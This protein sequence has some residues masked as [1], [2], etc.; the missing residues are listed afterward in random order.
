MSLRRAQRSPGLTRGSNLPRGIA[1]SLPLLAMTGEQNLLCPM[2]AP[3]IWRTSVKARNAVIGRI[4]LT[5]LAALALA[6]PAMANPME[7]GS[8]FETAR[9]TYGTMQSREDGMMQA[10]GGPSYPPPEPSSS[11]EKQE[12]RCGIP[13][14]TKGIPVSLHQGGPAYA[15]ALVAASELISQAEK[16]RIGGGGDYKIEAAFVGRSQKDRVLIVLLEGSWFC[17]SGGCSIY[18]YGLKNNRWSDLSFQALGTRVYLY[19]VDKNYPDLSLRDSADNSVWVARFDERRGLYEDCSLGTSSQQPQ[20]APS[21][22]AVS[23]IPAP[24]QVAA[25]PQQRPAPPKAIEESIGT[26]YAVD[27]I[28]SV[29]TNRHVVT[30]CT[31]LRMRRGEQVVAA[32]L[33]ASDEGNDLAVLRGN[34]PGLLPVH[35]RE[36]KGIRPADTVVAIGYPYAGLLSSTPQVTTGTV[37]ALAGIEDDSRFLQITAPVQPGN[38]GGPLFDLSGNV[39]GDCGFNPRPPDYRKGHRFDSAERQ[40]CHQGHNGSRVSR[41][42]GHC[43]YDS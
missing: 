35:F 32:E 4:V 20:S 8:G 2:G 16:N 40:L 18:A 28:G 19:N 11:P 29:V 33:I 37:T 23:A 21:A 6:G 36:G 39:V 26:G 22:P 43:L 41:R 9:T 1:A 34:L 14:G 7:D 42:Q 24:S 31:R 12:S 3:V 15:A 38:S 27:D 17:G 25:M 10:Q 5:V 13:S 30:G